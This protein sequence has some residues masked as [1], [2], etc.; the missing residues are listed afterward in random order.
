MCVCPVHLFRQTLN[1]R[2]GS[3]FVAFVAPC[4]VFIF[5][6]IC[7]YVVAVAQRI[8]LLLLLFSS[9]IELGTHRSEEPSSS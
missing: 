7:N 5:W 1:Y 6:P 2:V 9:P 8:L 3:P 4:L